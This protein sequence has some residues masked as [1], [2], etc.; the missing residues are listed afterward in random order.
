MRSYTLHL[1][2]LKHIALMQ[3]YVLDFSMADQ[4]C[5]KVSWTSHE[6][7]SSKQSMSTLSVLLPSQ[8]RP[9][10]LSKSCCKWFSPTSVICS[11]CKQTHVRWK[12]GHSSFYWCDCFLEGIYDHSRI[13]GEFGRQD[14]HGFIVSTQLSSCLNR[15]FLL[16]GCSC[17]NRWPDPRWH[18]EGT[19]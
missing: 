12:T 2:R 6:K 3:I 10:S 15:Y 13:R 4:L 16:S 7:R 18:R 5:R 8:G 9:S 14:I 11:T 17:Y 19:S 1:K